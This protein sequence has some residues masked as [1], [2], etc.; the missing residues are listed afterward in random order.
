M[1]TN[2]GEELVFEGHPSWR[3]TLLFYVKGFVAALVLGAIA[4]FA[5]SH[6]TGVLV[7]V[8][9]IALTVLAGLLVRMATVYVITS[10]RLYIKRGLI[11]RR[12]QECRLTR[13]QNVTVSQ[14]PVE[15][16]L[17][18]GRAEFDTAS[19]DEND[20][21]FVGIEHPDRIRAAVDR[22][23]RAH[24]RAGDSPSL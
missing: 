7:A 6:T 19:D 8:A 20:F 11:A 22:A 2:P 9:G 17:A 21:A 4:W 5:F 16:L 13:V 3:A 18:V 24:E 15:R 1:D 23:H 10:E 12:V 14:G